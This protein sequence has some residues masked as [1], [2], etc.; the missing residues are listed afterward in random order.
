M[1]A[2]DQELLGTVLFSNP[3]RRRHSVE[4]YTIQF[5]VRH[6]AGIVDTVIVGEIGPQPAYV[7][8]EVVAEDAENGVAA[9]RD[10]D[11]Q[12]ILR[13]GQSES[14]FI[15]QHEFAVFV[16]FI[17]PRRSTPSSPLLDCLKT[18]GLGAA[19]AQVLGRE[20]VPGE[21]AATAATRESYRLTGGK[22]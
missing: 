4:A 12:A 10:D 14:R 5:S 6:I 11:H 15:V 16:M 21:V 20:A 3:K 19:V 8:D 18:R 7:E 1:K 13:N 2:N 17:T 9:A 22:G